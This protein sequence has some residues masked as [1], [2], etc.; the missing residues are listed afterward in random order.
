M[1]CGYLLFHSALRFRHLELLLVRVLIPCSPVVGGFGVF[2]LSLCSTSV[3]QRGVCWLCYP[4]QG[5]CCD[6]DHL[7]SLLSEGA[8]FPA[9][10]WVHRGSP[11]VTVGSAQS[12]CTVRG[13]PPSTSGVADCHSVEELGF[14]L[15]D[16]RQVTLLQGGAVRST[17]VLCA[18]GEQGFL[19]HLQNGRLLLSSLQCG[20][21]HSCFLAR[22]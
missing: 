2:F 19:C 12:L 8:G 11:A 5:S 1:G 22:L 15:L 14:Q 21:W 6:A 7:F 18:L 10:W 13:R 16:R 20:I 17:G 3:P 4:L 9:A